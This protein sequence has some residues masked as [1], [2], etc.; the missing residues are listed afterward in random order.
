MSAMQTIRLP[1]KNDARWTALVAQGP[2]RPIK[3]LALKFM[4]AR[5]SQDIKRDPSPP[6]VG[7]KVDELHQFFTANARMLE[8]DTALLFG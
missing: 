3:L 5:M 1:P 8:A 2:A 6:N 4:L 7:K